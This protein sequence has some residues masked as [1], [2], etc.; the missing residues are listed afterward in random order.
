MGVEHLGSWEAIL[1]PAKWMV[2]R[3]QDGKLCHNKIS[4]ITYSKNRLKHRTAM[5]S[6][7]SMFRCC[8]KIFLG[9]TYRKWR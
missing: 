6:T 3:V 1:G 2:I 8:N 4:S 5:A 7:T 9:L